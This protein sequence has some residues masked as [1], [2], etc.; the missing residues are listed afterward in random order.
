MRIPEEK[1]E[2][3]RN[4]TDIVDYIGRYVKLKKRGKSYLGVCPFHNEKTPSF[5][6]SSDKQMYYCFGCHRGGD[7]IKFAM[8]W[9][10]ITYPEAIEMLAERAG[11]HMPTT[12]RETAAVNE[13]ELLHNACRFAGR[14]YYGNLQ[15]PEGKFAY[16]Y[17]RARGFTDKTITTFGLGYAMRSWDALLHK[18]KEEGITPEHL[19]KVGLLR[20][21]DD[22]TQYDAFRGRAMFPIFTAT[23]KVIAF[24]A[25]KI[26]DDD[27]VPGKYINS[28]ETSIYKKSRVLYGLSQ[29]KEAIREADAVI[30]VEGYADLISVFQ[31]GVKNIVASSGTAL[32]DEQIKL[33]SRYTKNVVFVYDADSAGAHA[34]VRG[35]DLI[36]EANMDVRIVPLPAGEDPDSFVK[37]NGGEAFRQLVAKAQSFIDFKASTFE[38]DGKFQTP[39]GRAEA[40]RGLVQTIA[41]IPDPLKQSFFIREVSE[42]YKLYESSLYTEL[43][44]FAKKVERGPAAQHAEIKPQAPSTLR[45]RQGEKTIAAPEELCTEEKELLNALFEDPDTMVQFIFGF[46]QIDELVSQTAKD[47]VLLVMESI[48]QEG[49]VDPRALHE[50][51]QDDRLRRIIADCSFNRYQLSVKWD[52][53]GHRTSDDRLYEQSLGAI[54]GLKRR[55][56][57]NAIAENRKRMRDAQLQGSDV[58]ELL[59]IEKELYQ[60]K[61]IIEEMKLIREQ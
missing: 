56:I 58:L 15:T 20:T 21:R 28:P 29:A 52:S 4:A 16:D 19:A 50:R 47:I 12:E 59:R 61:Q 41:K 39:E 42:K 27:T 46:I 30:L 10:K 60:Q 8:E 44:K 55:N 6:V 2:E 34:M 37:A 26:Y 7:V 17:F 14:Y 9:D 18:A 49:R 53:I 36:L 13:S 54:K 31:A 22:G 23:G 11:I 5:N 25:R 43:E 40:V 33:L 48:E 45:E 35:I 38:K 1:I 24:G 57:E 32:T 51:T 3:V